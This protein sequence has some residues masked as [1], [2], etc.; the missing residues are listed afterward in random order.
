MAKNKTVKRIKHRI[1]K[2][3]A[4]APISQ[5][6]HGYTSGHSTICS[7][8]PK[9]PHGYSAGHSAMCPGGNGGK[10]SLL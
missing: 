7:G 4:N 2:S 9:C 5:C 10:Y 6:E 8:G 1:K 3:R